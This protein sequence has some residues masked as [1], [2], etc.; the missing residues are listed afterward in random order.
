MRVDELQK[1]AGVTCRHVCAT[2]CAIYP[3]RPQICRPFRCLWLSGFA[4]LF[5][6]DERPDKTGMVPTLTDP[7]IAKEIG[8]TA[9]MMHYGPETNIAHG[10]A[11]TVLNRLKKRY[12]VVLMERG[13]PMRAIGPRQLMPLWE[14]IIGVVREWRE[15]H[16]AMGESP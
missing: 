11:R 7:K 13:K 8:A 15:A 3:T 16:G 2:G 10:K 14:T 6:E 5:H 4:N 1:P 9:I 12:P